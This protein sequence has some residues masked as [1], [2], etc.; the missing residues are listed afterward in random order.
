LPQA[1]RE[2]SASEQRLNKTY[3]LDAWVE[4][5]V[6]FHPDHTRLRLTLRSA[7][8][9][10]FVLAREDIQF[11]AMPTSGEVEKNVQ[12]ALARVATTLAHDGRITWRK[13]D[14]VVIDFGKERGLAPGTE[15][16][17]GYVV[18]SAR[19][20]VSQ[21]YL[22]A[23]KIQTLSLQVIEARDGSSVCRIVRNHPLLETEANNL[24]PGLTEKGLL[25]W[26][27]GENKD[28][29]W[30]EFGGEKRSDVGLVSGAEAGFSARVSQPTPTSTEPILP[31]A[32]STQAPAQAIAKEL[33]VAAP[34]SEP[35]PEAQSDSPPPAPSLASPK[36]PEEDEEDEEDDAPTSSSSTDLESLLDFSRWNPSEASVGLGVAGGSLDS[37]TGTLST[38]FPSTL[39]NS[40]R[41]SAFLQYSPQIYMEPEF[42]YHFFSGTVDGSRGEISLPLSYVTMGNVE[43]PTAGALAVGLGPS[44]LFG[45][46]KSVRTV[47]G[48]VR[49]TSQTFQ[50]FD[51]S[52][53]VQYMHAISAF[54][55]AKAKATI[56]VAEVLQGEGAALDLRAQAIPS[57]YLPKE[58]GFYLG[59]RMGPGIWSGYDLGATWSLKL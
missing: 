30:L 10:S 42:F 8:N 1:N 17:A 46:V 41:V 59:Y 29:G 27:M 56:A 21:E 5:E 49:T 38:D 55:V 34:Q 33:P 15:L 37:S 48:R 31:I 18:L 16:G 58:L 25:A 9:R 36:A 7:R 45:E 3:D 23:Q 14:L 28:V 24:V 11:E 40:V 2:F 19:H 47:S 12:N 39:L 52:I 53:H 35:Q 32:Q 54:G 44:F 26:R 6:V 43:N 13:N 4:S 51:A 22:R 20:P 50:A 57:A